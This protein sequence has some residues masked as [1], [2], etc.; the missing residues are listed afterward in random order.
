LNVQLGRGTRAHKGRHAASVLY[1]SGDLR[2]NGP[3]EFWKSE[4]SS[5]I[6]RAQTRNARI[7]NSEQSPSDPGILEGGAPS[8]RRLYRGG[9][10]IALANSCQRFVFCSQSRRISECESPSIIARRMT[11]AQPSQF[12]NYFESSAECTTNP[13]RLRLQPSC[14]CRSWI[15]A[16]P[17]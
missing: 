5:A 12:A 13:L 8:V 1:I 14:S 16:A 4:N 3:T 15:T 7:R 2:R 9:L 17:G 10:K 6:P 11:H